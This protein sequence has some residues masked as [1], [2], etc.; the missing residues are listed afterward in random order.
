MEQ[1]VALP[2]EIPTKL[3]MHNR[4]VWEHMDMLLNTGEPKRDTENAACTVPQGLHTTVYFDGV[5][6]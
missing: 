5:Y 6:H 4:E 1:L 2:K 3:D